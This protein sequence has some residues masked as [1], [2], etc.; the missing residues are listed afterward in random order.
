M[1]RPKNNI[2]RELLGKNELYFSV[3]V[4]FK[5][6]FSFSYKH[7]VIVFSF[8]FA[9]CEFFKCHY[10]PALPKCIYWLFI[11]S[12]ISQM[13][14]YWFACSSCNTALSYTHIVIVC[15]LERQKYA[16]RT[17]FCLCAPEKSATIF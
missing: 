4:L 2:L 12:E 16:K 8:K 9:K 6:P 3:C 10:H 7:I 17:V 5:Q 11:T 1:P 14:F 15:L 13:I